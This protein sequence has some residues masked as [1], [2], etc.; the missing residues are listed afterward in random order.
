MIRARRV[1]TNCSK[2]HLFDRSVLQPLQAPPSPLVEPLPPPLVPPQQAGHLLFLLLRQ[3]LFFQSRLKTKSLG[4]FQ[5][6]PH[7]SIPCNN[8]IRI[9]IIIII[10]IHASFSLSFP[11]FFSPNF[12]HQALGNAFVKENFTFAQFFFQN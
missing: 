3:L 2:L 8:S 1:L 9:I 11:S 4:L 10:Y 6:L 7:P 5:L 12:A